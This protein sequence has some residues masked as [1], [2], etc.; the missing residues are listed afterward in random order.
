VH[1]DE[2]SSVE[3]AYLAG[4]RRLA[5]TAA[6]LT[7]QHAPALLNG[8]VSLSL[9]KRPRTATSNMTR[10]EFLGA[11]GKTKEY[12]QVGVASRGW[13]CVCVCVCVCV[14]GWGGG[15]VGG[16]GGGQAGA[17]TPK[18]DARYEWDWGLGEL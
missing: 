17:A 16:W 15:G 5:A 13:W 11:V 2:H 4:R 7:T 14:G 6:R 18:R 12:I 3:E 1:L 9:S 10:E 8:R